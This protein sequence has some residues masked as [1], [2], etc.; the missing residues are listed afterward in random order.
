MATI[1][2]SGDNAGLDTAAIQIIEERLVHVRAF[3]ERH[4][5][6]NPNWS[7]QLLLPNAH[8]QLLPLFRALEDQVTKIHS[9]GNAIDER[10]RGRSV[11]QSDYLL[12]LAQVLGLRSMV[13][14]QTFRSCWERGLFDQVASVQP[15]GPIDQYLPP[16]PRLVR[17]DYAEV[18]HLIRA[19]LSK[20]QFYIIRELEQQ[21]ICR[22]DA[23]AKA[24]AGAI[25]LIDFDAAAAARGVLLGYMEYGSVGLICSS[26]HPCAAGLILLQRYAADVQALGGDLAQLRADLLALHATLAS[27]TPSLWQAHIL[28]EP[29]NSPGRQRYQKKHLPARKRP[30]FI[31]ILAQRR[32]CDEAQATQLLDTLIERG[33]PGLIDLRCASSNQSMQQTLIQRRIQRAVDRN[34]GAMHTH[35]RQEIERL[36]EHLLAAIEGIG[37]SFSLVPLLTSH[38]SSP[39]RIRRGRRVWYGAAASIKRIQRRRGR[40]RRRRLFRFPPQRSQQPPETQQDKHGDQLVIAFAERAELTEA[41]A[42]RRLRNLI[43]YGGIGLLAEKDWKNAVD[44]R[45]REVVHFFKLA[46]VKGTIDWSRMRRQINSELS[47]LQLTPLSPQLIRALFNQGS[48]PNFW[49]SGE[50][51]NVARVSK[52]VTL[53]VS[54]VPRL[55]RIWQVVPVQ[56][57]VPVV[58]DSHR[59]LSERCFV[60]LVVDDASQLPIGLWVSAGEPSAIELGLALYQSIWHPGALDWPLHGSPEIILIPKSLYVQDLTDIERSTTF[61][62]AQIDRLPKEKPLRYLDVVQRVR[63]QGPKHLRRLMGSDR[64]TCRQIHDELL[65]WLFAECFPNHRAARVPAVYRR[66][67]VTLPLHDFPVAGWLLPRGE[68][69]VETSSNEVWNSAIAYTSDVYQLPGGRTLPYRAF[70][71]RYGGTRRDH[72]VAPGIFVEYDG[73]LQYLTRRATH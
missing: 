12:P 23:T 2:H 50:S 56:L 16:R 43:T 21:R 36:L 45:T 18:M 31:P 7:D 60:L 28:H 55:H 27:H 71:Y 29:P 54:K 15:R 25:K 14:A 3:F 40:T 38:P 10:R 44:M 57:P 34:L 61:L 26:P 5:G 24:V 19:L 66:Q 47:R 37:S 4:L 9:P 48:V 8:A 35:M 30:Q 42:R 13:E 67:G 49:H 72:V 51:E 11:W 20:N 64:F 58:D 46:R 32:G 1:L 52:R 63:E 73:T 33:L 39:Y 62:M 68:N 6:A 17:R 41:E 59:L 69:P 53:T 70:P 65:T 22:D